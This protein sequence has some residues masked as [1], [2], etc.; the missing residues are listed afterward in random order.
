MSSRAAARYVHRE[1][2]SPAAFHGESQ[3]ALVGADA[4][5]TVAHVVDGTQIVNS[6]GAVEIEAPG[7][8]PACRSRGR[9][10]IRW[11]APGIPGI[12]FSAQQDQKH[13]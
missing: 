5:K 13:R 3:G 2:G 9:G 8:D 12:V 11:Q 10:G 7:G 1:F 4:A 6:P